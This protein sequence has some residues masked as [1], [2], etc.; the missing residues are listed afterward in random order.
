MDVVAVE[1]EIKDGIGEWTKVKPDFMLEGA[2]KPFEVGVVPVDND[3]K[4]SPTLSEKEKIFTSKPKSERNEEA[5]Q[6]SVEKVPL[7]QT[8][9]KQLAKANT[10]SEIKMKESEKIGKD[11]LYGDDAGTG[12]KGAEQ[13]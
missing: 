9:F 13:K 7:I 2:E 10:P 6:Q 12:S 11:T 5:S 4:P 8:K 3:R 1:K